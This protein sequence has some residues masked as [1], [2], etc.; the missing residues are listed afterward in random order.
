MTETQQQPEPQPT[1]GAF[2]RFADRVRQATPAWI[3]NNG[4]RINFA[5]KALADGTGILSSVRRGSES[6]ARLIANSVT[7]A[8]LIP[9]SIYSEKVPT[10]DEMA[11]EK[12]M[13]LIPYMGHRIKSAF[14]PKEHVVEMVGLATMANGALTVLSGVNQ[15]SRRQLSW[16]L[17]TGAFTMMAGG[18]LTF[19]QDRQR[20]WQSWTAIFLGRTPFKLM[21][22][23]QAYSRGY[24]DR[25]IRPG[26]KY[27]GLNLGI[28]LFGNVFSTF[29]AGVK[30]N[31]DGTITHLGAK[32]M[33]ASAH[34]QTQLTQVGEHEPMTTTPP[35][36]SNART[37]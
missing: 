2:D 24:V 30:K 25:N 32:E 17:V 9:G 34:P 35:E 19:M 31:P 1:Q 18:A 36:L 11:R 15:S 28:Q 21:Q 26:D 8:T 23:E 16:E 14:N 5:L 12:E 7:L 4:T 20:A 13:G 6:P 10:Q 3:V 29:Y 37:A 27:Q 33:A 22:S